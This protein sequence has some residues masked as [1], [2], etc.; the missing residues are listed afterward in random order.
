MIQVQKT[1]Q[2]KVVTAKG[3]TLVVAIAPEG[4]Y[5]KELRTRRA[6]LLPWGHI[7]TRAAVLAADATRREKAA[8]RKA[9]KVATKAAK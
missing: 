5:T 6:Y 7:H 1:I 4:V 3:Q 8:K 2:R 9:K